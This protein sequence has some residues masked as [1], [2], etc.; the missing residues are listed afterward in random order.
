MR[1]ASLV[2]LALA[3]GCGK[4]ESAPKAEAPAG[5]VA[6]A[7][8]APGEL[9]ATGP[10][11]ALPIACTPGETCEVQ[12]YYD[13]DPGPGARDYRCEG[14]TYQ[15]H[16]GVDIRIPDMAALRAG[17]DVV[18]AAPGR[19]ARLRDGVA[20]ISMRAPGAPSVEG[21][22]C[23]NGV[24]VDHGD[25]WETQYCHLRQGSVAVKVGDAVTTGQPL[26]KVGLSGNTE[27]PHLHF[28]VRRAGATL[29]PFAPDPADKACA[30]KGALWTEAAYRALAYRPGAVLNTGF[31]SDP[32]TMAAIEDATT[33]PAHA[34]GAALVAYARAIGLRQG[35]ELALTLTGPD[36]KVL[37]TNR[38]APLDRDKAQYFVFIGKRTPAGGWPK[39]TY[40]A[41]F[42]VHR[43]G[44]VALTRTFR[45]GL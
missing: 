39:G 38:Q 5:A 41:R 4:P 26:A 45:Q 23:G 15:D 33:P 28:T 43:N 30:A 8:L 17:V 6:P 44:A 7:T 36:G 29:D 25:G 40:S 1:H 18:A 42:D 20:D 24:V 31:A 22:M 37:L 14:R 27:F 11:L 12:S 3:T 9:A 19:V 13:R 21:Q 2:L 10:R 35:D 16:N 34:G 32:V